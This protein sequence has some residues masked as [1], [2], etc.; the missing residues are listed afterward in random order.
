[1]AEEEGITLSKQELQALVAMIHN[2]VAEYNFY[3]PR[4]GIRDVSVVAPDPHIGALRKLLPR[5][6][7]DL[8]GKR[9][10]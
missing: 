4:D 2:L 10:R 1:M 6:G 9:I 7:L 8:Q 3:H 5:M